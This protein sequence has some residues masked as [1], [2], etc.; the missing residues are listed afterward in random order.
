MSGGGQLIYTTSS[1]LQEENEEIVS[2]FLKQF[3]S[4]FELVSAKS[5][6][7]RALPGVPWPFEAQTDFVKMLPSH[8]IGTVFV[9]VLERKT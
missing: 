8:Q 4:E 5:V 7:E 1:L 2:K 6:W 3:R 9:A